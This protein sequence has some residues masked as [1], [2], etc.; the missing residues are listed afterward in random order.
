M[1]DGA[2]DMLKE[3]VPHDTPVCSFSQDAIN[4]GENISQ[5]YTHKDQSALPLSEVTQ[6]EFQSEQR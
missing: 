2:A 3:E 4:F 5:S 6:G 1:Q